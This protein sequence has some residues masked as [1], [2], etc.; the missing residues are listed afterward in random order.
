MTYAKQDD[1]LAWGYRFGDLVNALLACGCNAQSARW[2]P[3]LPYRFKFYLRPGIRYVLTYHDDDSDQP[4]RIVVKK[5]A[6]IIPIGRLEIHDDLQ[7]PVSE[8]AQQIYDWAAN[9]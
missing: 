8:T 2:K 6:V 1:G 4:G 3:G 5:L 7:R 9:K